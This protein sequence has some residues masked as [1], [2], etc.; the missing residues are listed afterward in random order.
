MKKLIA[1]I[2][3]LTMVMGLFAGCNQKKT[4]PTNPPTTTAPAE[5]TI[6]DAI[7]YL[8]AIYKDEGA[9][10]PVDYKRFQ[11]VR[12][13]GI[14]FEVEWTVNIGE[15]MIK[16]VVNE[17]GT[18][19]INVNEECEKDTPY[20]LTAT[21]KDKSGKS[22]SHSWNYVLP[23]KV[24]MIDIVKAAYALKSGE[25]LPYESTLTGKIISVDTGW[26]DDTKNIT[27]TIE[28]EGIEDKPVQCYKMTGDKAKELGIGDTITVTG[29]LT[30]YNGTIEFASGC[31]LDAVTFGEKVEAP[32]DHKQIVD[33]A[34]QL[35]PGKSLPYEATLTGVITE[36]DTPYND[37]YKNVSVIITVK[38][39]EDKPILV[40]RVKGEGA[41]DLDVGDTVTVKGYITNY[42][43]SS[44]NKIEFTAGCV[45]VSY[46][47]T[48]V[49]TPEK[50]PVQTTLAP[51]LVQKPAVNTAYKFYMEQNNL[52]QILYFTG[53]MKGYYLATSEDPADAV[54]MFVESVN[55]GYRVYFMKDNAKTY[56]ELAQSGTHINA[57]LVTQPTMTFTYDEDLDTIIGKVG[58]DQYYIGTYSTHNTFGPSKISFVTGENA[59]S[60]GVSNFIG[61]FCTLVEKETT[62]D[63]GNKEDNKEEDKE[64]DKEN[65]G[66][67][68]IKTEIV[69]NPAADVAYKLGLIQKKLK[70]EP[71]LY[72]SGEMKGYY[73]ATTD[74]AEKA[75][76]IILKAVAGGYHLSFKDST[77]AVKYINITQEAKDG[78]VYNNAVIGDTA[79]T[80]F[81]LNTELNILT[82][83]LA[84]GNTYYIGT[85]GTFNTFSVSKIDYIT[86]DKAGDLDTYSFPSRIMVLKEV[87]GAATV[88]EAVAQLKKDYPDGYGEGNALTNAVKVRD[89]SFT[90][91]WK[92]E[93]AN[94]AAVKIEG[95]KLVVVQQEEA[96]AFKLIATVTAKDGKT[97][98][99]A[100]EYTVP[101]KT[102]AKRA[103]ADLLAKYG[104]FKN[105]TALPAAYTFE[106]V[107]FTL[108]WS[109]TSDAQ[110]A[111]TI[112]DGALKLVPQS[113]D[114]AFVL[115]VTVAKDSDT[116]TG[117]YEGIVSSVS[118][119][120]VIVDTP[121]AGMA[122]KLALSQKNLA[123]M[124]LLFF[125]GATESETITYRLALSD[126]MDAAI[127]VCLEAVEGGYY[128][129]FMNGETKTYIRLYE[130]TDG[131][132]GKGKGSLE[133]VTEAP[134]EFYTYSEEFKTLIYTADADNSY[135]LG[136]YSTFNTISVSNTSFLDAE[137]CDVSQ[138]PVH[139]YT[140]T[141]VSGPATLEE[142]VTQL[143]KDH[144]YGYD[145]D[146]SLVGSVQ[147]RSDVFSVAWSVEAS[148]AAAVKIEGGKLVVAQ[149][150]EVVT[151]KLIATV[152]AKD[153]TS[154]TVVWEYTVPAK[155]T[156]KRA[157]A[158]LLA[159]YTNFKD[160]SALPATYTF[161]DVE[162]VLTW[163]VTADV[164]GAA[165][166]V[167][168]ALKLV[169][170]SADVA[171]VLSVTV[172]KD[173]DTATGTYE[174]V[175]SCVSIVPEIVDIPVAGTGYKLGLIQSNL[176]GEP[177][178]YFNGKM[179]GFYLATTENPDE[180]V[181]VY[182]EVVDGGYL[183][184]FMQGDVKTYIRMSERTDK[185][186][187]GTLALT[188]EAP[189]EF[190][191]YDADNKT[192]IHTN[193]TSGTSFFLGTYSEFTT[194]S[195]SNAKYL[196]DNFKVHFITMKEIQGP[197]SLE[198]G[199]AQLKKDHPNGYDDD[200][201]LAESVQ[202]RNDI[203]NIVWTVDPADSA[204]VSVVD[205]KLVIVQQD[206]AVEFKL[207]ATVTAKDGTSDTVVWEYTILAN[208]TAKRASEALMFELK[209]FVNDMVLPATFTFENVEYAVAWSITTDNAAA[210]Y[211]EDGVLKLVPQSEEVTYLLTATLTNGDDSHAINT[212]GTVEKKNEQL[213]VPE[214]VETPKV[215]VAY[216]LYLSQAG[217]GKSLYFNG[218]KDPSSQYRLNSVDDMLQAV[219]VYLEAVDGVDGGYRLYFMDGEVKTYIRVYEYQSG[220]AYKGS[221]GYVT[222]APEEYYTYD[223]T[224]NTLVYTSANG[225]YYL[226]TYGTYTTF[227]VSNTSYLTADKVDVSQFPARL[228]ELELRPLIPV[229]VSAPTVDTAYKLSL[230][231][232][233]I[234][235]SLY[236]NGEK[237]PS[238]QYRLNS[239]DDMLQAVD[240]YLEA[241]DGV[242]GGYRLYFMD[243]EVKT[244]IRVYEYQSGNAYKGSMGYVTEAPEEY[245]TYDTTYNT[246]VYTS[247]NGAYYLGTYGTYTTFS[248][249]NTSYL[250]A[251]KVDVSQFPA[252]FVLLTTM[253]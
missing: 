216:K 7:A 33:E 100:W 26:S 48:G 143:K 187:S 244:Y 4:D 65:G 252:R 207:I 213:Y 167:D 206:V 203:F 134:A 44:G 144:P 83:K 171:Y 210:A 24:N 111:A 36:I 219:D 169:P 46:E 82:T 191:T 76:D 96:V 204:A 112:V 132:A 109:V 80:V 246:L 54:D 145:E 74:D 84:D 55:G 247:A 71:I 52:D 166:I 215:G 253:A 165:T 102:T 240:V 3:L 133:F 150:E 243:G 13:A 232:V 19:T 114:V 90:V 168:G 10:T 170:Q 121:V 199:V 6:E 85:Y 41:D 117:T 77:G 63:E 190:Y 8:K 241:V 99:A 16:V 140:L 224:Y 208:T 122:Y 68:S 154:D 200:Y 192:V 189:A 211:I 194:L 179:S 50:P 106:D 39:R 248:V 131:D 113:T 239:V 149:Q 174:G 178:L 214:I 137:N 196:A 163:T 115:S 222:E 40:Y 186:G 78:K 89:D 202:V 20:V 32:T 173:T 212:E 237:D 126:D 29:T 53:E 5:A 162:F 129:Y 235:K 91:T 225:A 221:M 127:D 229:M 155:T 51:E 18:A 184:Y 205:G 57:V 12:I 176:P 120:P 152:T 230:S 125:T 60:I 172:A 158:D 148:N 88:D 43:G 69:T 185:A 228:V 153:G 21:I 61:H 98:T 70:G 195:A 223:T 249:S 181:D 156:A 151:Y 75:V 198:E 182:L 233:G 28:I 79:S 105:G 234:G 66:T 119:V 159:K 17:D 86:G 118:I 42:V 242:D 217:L 30:N 2:L 130:R 160:G 128:L 227:S 188:E 23:K 251:D 37:Q 142:G 11:I 72:F 58:E 97:G 236:F 87:Q 104:S 175:I 245:Y 56:L 124:P 31:Q 226:G 164:E 45:L 161:E 34:Y 193:A 139:F 22:V 116:A 147:V 81:T 138:F 92:V 177:M 62:G 73:L 250:T 27:V 59:E 93:T 94:A 180:A 15:D 209:S 25:S 183:M 136:T 103:L 231:Q 64:D 157:L 49:E 108:S 218:E 35:E 95:G 197:A 135:Y 201:V 238:S 141:E 67:S 123:G 14:P 110:G 47:N 9:K 1:W 38:G 220:N 107:E 101:A 146:L